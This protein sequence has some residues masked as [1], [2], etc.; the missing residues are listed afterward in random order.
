MPNRRISPTIIDAVH[1]DLKL[2]PCDQYSLDNGAK[3]YSLNA[4]AEEVIMLEFVF[5]AGNCY[6]PYNLVAAATNYLLKNGT[7]HKNAFQVNEHFE[8][9]GAYL[10]RA[11]QNETATVTLHCLS[12]HLKELLPAVREVLMDSVFPESELEIFKQNS[13]QRLSVNLQKCDFVA[14]RLIDVYL[15]GEDHPYGKFSKHEDYDALNSDDLKSF[16][17]D[18]Y[19]HGNAVLFAAGKLP[20]NFPAILN[21]FFGD[22]LINQPIPPYSNT[23]NTSTEKKFRIQNDPNGVQG[24]IRLA[25]PF[26]NRHH[27]DFQK[28]MVLNNLFGGFFGS[29]LMGN[30]REEK[31][32]TYG[33]H[34][35]IQNHIQESAWLVSTEAGKDVCEATIEEVYNEME[36]LRN[37][38]VDEEELLL[39]KN[40][41][42]GTNLGDLDGPFQIIARWKT[43]FLNNL[44]ESYFYDSMNAIKS[45]TAKEIQ[46]L[47]NKYLRPEDFFE[48][49]V[50]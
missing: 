35:Y 1:F 36:L 15:Y 12:K 27:P 23:K 11:C 30:I 19:S 20:E 31:G 43:L 39:V 2:K 37:E 17:K 45:V 38:L 47:A 44:E 3:V 48:L 14:N 29:R 40:Y 42:M 22:L 4:G 49:V 41:M 24:A 8:Y 26:P 50:I 18:H 28:V 25:R 34:S 21:Q 46:E 10:N 13:K 9:Y 7:S 5:R 6:E 16:Y 33:I 32:Y